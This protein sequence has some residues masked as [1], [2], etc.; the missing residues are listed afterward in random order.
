MNF[1]FEYLVYVYVDESGYVYTYHMLSENHGGQKR[2]LD[3]LE[4][5]LQMILSNHVDTGNKTWV[6]CKST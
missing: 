4:L 6:L 1:F 5:E 2:V 3:F